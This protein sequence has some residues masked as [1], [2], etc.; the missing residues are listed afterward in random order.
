[1]APKP[2]IRDVARLAGCSTATVSRVL[3]QSGPA[4]AATRQKVLAAAET[5]GFQFSDLGRSLQS[6]RTRTIGC[7]VPS[8]VNPVFADAVQMIQAEALAAGYHLLLMCS[9]YSADLE[10]AAIR[11]LLRKSVEGMVLTVSDARDSAGLALLRARRLRHCLMFNAPQPGSPAIHVDNGA[12]SAEVARAFATH[13]HRHTGFLALRFSA[14]DRSRQRFEGFC[15]GCA[16]AGIA[17]PALLE[18]DESPADLNGALRALLQDNAELTGLFA[19]NDFLGLAALRCARDLGRTVPRDL[20]VVGFDGISV[21]QMIEPQLATVETDARA[22]GREAARKV[23]SAIENDRA[24]E[25]PGASLPYRFRCGGS[26]GRPASVSR[27]DEGTAMP[28]PPLYHPPT[29]NTAKMERQS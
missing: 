12:A 24:V 19:S 25:A 6:S 18:I 11:Q 2:T 28:S 26:L 13:G 22:M 20:S 1:M 3:N 23:I 17:P 7:I 29:N 8:I 15:R 14:S 9:D 27:D 10:E 16:E 5:L 4:G 21:G